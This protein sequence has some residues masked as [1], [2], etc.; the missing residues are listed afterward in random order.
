MPGGTIAPVFGRLLVLG[1]LVLSLLMAVTACDLVRPAR[2]P[3]AAGSPTRAQLE[4]LLTDIPTVYRRPFPGG[5][6]RSCRSGHGCVF[7][8]AW[9][10]DTDAP[11]GRDGCDTRNNVL[12]L[13]LTAVS[14]RPG[15]NDC[16]VQSGTLVDPYTGET[17]QF[18]RSDAK[19]VQI[20]H[21][22]PLAAAWDMGA[23]QWTS[24]R[25]I[26]FANDVDTNLLAVG[27]AENQAKGDSTPAQWLPPNPAY[28]CYYAGKF[29]TAARTYGL[30]ITNADRATL[31][32]VARRCE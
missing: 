13:Q 4:L 9:T 32:D 20:D 23:A 27:G 2:V 22:Y 8:P 18:R 26:R 25:R 7:G 12:A 16:V 24:E 3:P 5:Y 1:A 11:R 14:F 21:V 29:L 6:D 28:H 17:R 30:P 10:D 31:I 15:S 19:A